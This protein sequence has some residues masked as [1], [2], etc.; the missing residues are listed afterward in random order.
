MVLNTKQ[1][2][3][4]RSRLSVI[5][6][7]WLKLAKIVFFDKNQHYVR[8]HSLFKKSFYIYVFMILIPFEGS[9]KKFHHNFLDLVAVPSKLGGHESNRSNHNFLQKH[10]FHQPLKVSKLAKP[11]HLLV[12]FLCLACNE[13]IL[14]KNCALCIFNLKKIT[15]VHFG[16]F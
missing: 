2:D 5:F 13:S 12:F 8:R 16:H 6:E 7:S 10:D 11:T 9:K 1:K 3:S 14:F 15:R 4:G